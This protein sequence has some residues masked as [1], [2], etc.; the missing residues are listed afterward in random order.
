MAELTI[1][2]PLTREPLPCIS[3]NGTITGV[4]LDIDRFHRWSR[5][6]EQAA[7][8]DVREAELL[9]QSPAFRALIEKGLEE[10]KAG[11]TRPW[12]EVF[13]EL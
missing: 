10:V 4:I 11:Q 2:D 3:E 9:S 13:N 5:L 6:V 12:R 1:A 7:E 8:E